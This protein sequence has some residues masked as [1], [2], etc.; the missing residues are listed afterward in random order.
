[1]NGTG[2]TNDEIGDT[3]NNQFTT[4]DMNGVQ[5]SVQ[6]YWSKADNICI[7]PVGTLSFWVDKNTFGKDEVQDVITTNAGKWEK[8][9]WLVVEGYSK[10]S[11]NAL[12]VTVPLPTGPFANIPGVTITQNP[13]IEF[14]NGANPDVQQRIRIAFD[15]TF[16]S[17]SAQPL[18]RLPGSRP[19][20]SMRSSRPM[21]TRSRRTDAST[22]F[23]LVA[24]ADPY[25]TNIDPTQ[26]N[27]FY[28]SQ[29]LRVFTATPAQNS[30]P[31]PGGA[32]V[33]ERQPCRAHSPTCRTCSTT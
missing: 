20:N 2:V 8:A 23:E 7:L 19:T 6:A 32:G 24:G 16:T 21:A 26:N 30:H 27:V 22:L 17:A 1:M 10:T 13:V 31:V 25:F 14:E 33:H 4:V 5:C 11:F 9:F 12:H 29:D 3:C 18:P 15:I 28:L